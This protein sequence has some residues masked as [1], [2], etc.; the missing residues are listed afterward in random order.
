MP[1]SF[2]EILMNTSLCCKELK[3]SMKGILTLIKEILLH[4]LLKTVTL[5]YFILFEK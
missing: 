3:I 2:R 1:V 4:L 5:D